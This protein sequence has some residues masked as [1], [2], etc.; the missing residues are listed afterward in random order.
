MLCISGFRF[1]FLNY[2]LLHWSLY[3]RLFF[4]V[5]FNQYY[6]Q[7]YIGIGMKTLKTETPEYALHNCSML[8]NAFTLRLELQWLM[9]VS[10]W[11]CAIE[12]VGCSSLFDVIIL[13]RLVSI[14]WFLWLIANLYGNLSMQITCCLQQTR[15]LLNLQIL[16]LQG[17]NL[18]QRWWLQRLG[19]IAGWLLRF[20]PICFSGMDK[21]SYL[22]WRLKIFFFSLLVS[23][24]NFSYFPISCQLVISSPLCKSSMFFRGNKSIVCDTGIVSNI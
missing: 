13:S 24:N 3:L 14:S 15:V 2:L 19:L 17:K 5:A 7:F 23:Y 1:F 10:D 8:L 9:P 12:I 18:W 21:Q 22:Q 16:V 20:V 11:I 6:P 4:Y